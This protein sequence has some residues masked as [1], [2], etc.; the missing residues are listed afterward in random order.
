MSDAFFWGPRS[1]SRSSIVR[2]S[3]IAALLKQESRKKACCCFP[4]SFRFGIESRSKWT[5]VRTESCLPLHGRSPAGVQECRWFIKAWQQ[6]FPHLQGMILAQFSILNSTTHPVPMC[7]LI[8]DC[9]FRKTQDWGII[10]LSKTSSCMWPVPQVIPKAETQF[11]QW[12]QYSYSMGLLVMHDRNWRWTTA[13]CPEGFIHWGGR[14]QMKEIAKQSQHE[15]KH[16][17]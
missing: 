9:S 4:L 6:H 11:R 13:A 5:V 2:L 8:W 1:E 12:I 15:R 14:K 7:S 17:K 10:S 3:W 16:L